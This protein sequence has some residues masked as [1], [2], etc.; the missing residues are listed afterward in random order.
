MIGITTLPKYKTIMVLSRKYH[1]FHA[2]RLHGLTPLVGIECLQIKDGRILHP[3]APFLAG[4]GVGTE[5][6]ESNEFIIKR[7]QLICSG[8]HVRCLFKDGLSAFSFF[9]LYG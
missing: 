3:V 4:E 9:N 2:G 6:N 5:M 1:H 7:T 8:N